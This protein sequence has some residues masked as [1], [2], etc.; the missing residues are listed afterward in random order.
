MP[1]D[2][3]IDRLAK[4]ESPD[5]TSRTPDHEGRRIIRLD[6]HRDWGWQI[7]NFTKYRESASKEMLR[8]SEADRKRA[9]RSRH[10]CNPSP[11]PLSPEIQKQREKQTCPA[12]VPDS[13]GHVPDIEAYPPDKD[14]RNQS[15]LAQRR[16]LVE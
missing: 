6:P 1:L 14:F 10:G 12:S 3:V 13:P 4:L 15:G 11:T 16:S 9:Y 5:L 2:I 7:V 8:M